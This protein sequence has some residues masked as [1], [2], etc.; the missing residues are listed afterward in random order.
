MKAET[1]V[2]QL[3]THDGVYQADLPTLKQWVAEGLVLPTDKVRK[4]ELKWIEAGRAPTLRRVFAGEEVPEPSQE[5]APAPAADPRHSH[6]ALGD[7]HAAATGA[8]AMNAAPYAQDLGLGA[9]VG[10]SHF[11]EGSAGGFIEAVS[12]KDFPGVLPDISPEPSADAPAPAFTCQNHPTDAATLICRTCRETFC[13]SCPNRMGTSSVLLCPACGNF[14]DPLEDINERIALLERSTSGFGFGDFREA[15]A[16]PLKHVGSLIGGALL[17]SFLLL[18][19]LWG[20]L[21]APA[22]VFGCI[23]L[24][25]HRV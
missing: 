10:A 14:C 25:I 3:M 20:H 17:Y 2:W 8:H 19:G 1:E 12:T 15:L 21:L 22:L 7:A 4:G 11:D 24:V 13:R 16:Y 5:F 6:A 23:S 18:G 9:S